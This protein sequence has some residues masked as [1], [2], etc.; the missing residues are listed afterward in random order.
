M[1]LL[2]PYV[3]QGRRL[4]ADSGSAWDPELMVECQGWC[5][6]LV[7][8]RLGFDSSNLGPN[9]LRSVCLALSSPETRSLAQPFRIDPECCLI[10]HVVDQMDRAEVR[11]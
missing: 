8:M 2:R 10:E 3:L 9:L 11:L 4:E 6:L 1:H 7:Q 5:R